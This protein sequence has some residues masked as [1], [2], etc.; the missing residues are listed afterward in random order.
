MRCSSP[1][2]ERKA[3][4]QVEYASENQSVNVGLRQQPPCKPTPFGAI[5][6]THHQGE[7]RANPADKALGSVARVLGGADHNK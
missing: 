6:I 3:L 2:F 5:P 4:D 7:S 1:R